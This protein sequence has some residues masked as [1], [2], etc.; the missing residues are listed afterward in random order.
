MESTTDESIK[1]YVHKTFDDTFLPSL[2]DFVRIPNLSPLFDPEWNTNGLLMKAANHLKDFADGLGLQ[3]YTSEIVKEDDRTPVLFLTIEPFKVPEEDALTVL[4]YSHMDKQPWGDGWDADKKPDE[5]V[6]VN[7]KLFGRGGADDGY[8]MYSAL[9]GIKTCQ[10]HSLPHPRVYIFIEGSEESSEDDLVHY[11][12]DFIGGRFKHSLDLVI[13]LDSEA[14]DAQTFTST[15]SL[16]GIINFDLKVEAFKDNIHSG[17]S[18]V[19]ADTFT[20]A[21]DLI[22]RLE[23]KSTYLMKDEFQVDIPDYRVEEMKEMAKRQRRSDEL[24]C[25]KVIQ[26]IPTLL[27]GDTIDQNYHQIANYN[28]KSV[29][30]VIGAN[31]LPDCA[32][33]GNCLRKQTTLAISI[34]TPPTADV[35]KMFER[36]KELMTTDV[37]FNYQVSI[38]RPDIAA[39]WNAKAL[40]EKVDT[41]LNDAVKSSYGTNPVFQGCGGAIPFAGILGEKFPKADFLVTGSS[42]P[43][44]NAHGPNEN[45][46]LPS[47]RNLTT[48][49][50]FLFRNVAS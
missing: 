29:L 26:S 2:M 15:S 25:L 21:T 43:D 46:D 23:D 30:S 27:T 33:S 47:T 1:E 45:L 17:N 37:P 38:E 42:L 36:I 7:D 3:G 12:N 22:S 20:V 28:W 4:C 5:P 18:G 14:L 40:S 8:G 44:T 41:A 39:G 9:L 48:A 6:I 35:D 49:L 10:D 31:G 16:R 24:P 32:I 13:A 50:A 19:F 11:I 34:R